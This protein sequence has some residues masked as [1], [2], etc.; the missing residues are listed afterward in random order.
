MSNWYLT[1]LGFRDP[2]AARQL[3]GYLLNF[4]NKEDIGMISLPMDAD[5]PIKEIFSGY[6][7]GEGNF[8]WYMKSSS[9]KE[10]PDMSSKTLFV[11]VKDV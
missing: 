5:S 9:G 2:D 11:D 6:R 1:P 8:I 4:A 7:Y 10:L 3:L